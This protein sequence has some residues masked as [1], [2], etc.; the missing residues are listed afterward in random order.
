MKRN[1]Y[2]DE[3]GIP[4]EEQL[5]NSLKGGSFKRRLRLRRQRKNYGF[6]ERETWNL[7]H[8][9]IEWLYCHLKMYKRVTNVDMDACLLT[10]V[11]IDKDKVIEEMSMSDAYIFMT[12]VLGNY[13]KEKAEDFLVIPSK[14]VYEA[15]HMFAST[16]RAWWW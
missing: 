13:L 10:N 8:T 12:E 7:D 3:L 2:L 1:K 11:V 15:L 4:R 6:D 14:E 9:Y 5:C 16:F